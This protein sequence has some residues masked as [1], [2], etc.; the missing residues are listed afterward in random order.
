MK[1]LII[2]FSLSL[3]SCASLN[4]F[5]GDQNADLEEIL[6][7]DSNYVSQIKVDDKISLSIWNHDDMSIGSLFSIYNSNESYGKWVLVES[8]GKVTLPQIGRVQLQGLTCS[9]AAD[10]LTKLYSNKL[11][12]PVIVVKILNRQI[13]ILGEVRTPGTYT[14]EKES[15]T[16][17]EIIGNAQGFMPYADLEKIQLIRNG[18][19]YE[20]N[21]TTFDSNGLHSVIVHSGDIINVPSRRGKGLDQKAPTLIP[22]TSVAT[23]FAIVFSLIR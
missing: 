8:D 22:F 2:I 17:S 5:R 4:L 21:L 23:A 10:T 9:N 20:L 13:T 15:N 6:H 16:I 18:K 14:I 7:Q 1:L 3:Y 11:V 12:N 19:S